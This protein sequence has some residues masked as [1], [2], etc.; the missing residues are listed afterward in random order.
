MSSQV[1]LLNNRR[2]LLQHWL[3]ALVMVCFVGCTGGNG[4]STAEVKGVVT[5]DGAPL[6]SEGN[7]SFEPAAG[8]KMAVGTVQPDGS[9]VL[10][11]YAPGDGAV[12]GRHRVSVTPLVPL[13]SD[14]A[15]QTRTVNTGPIPSRYRS[16]QSSGWEF[17]VKPG[18]VNEFRL[19]MTSK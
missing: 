10:K 11:T 5:L 9:F 4:M 8:G 13:E 2:E 1:I 6:S 19:E 14:D 18:V 17:E 12:V 3:A 7:V 15:P 16:V